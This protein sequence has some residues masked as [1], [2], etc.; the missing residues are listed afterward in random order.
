MGNMTTGNI[1]NRNMVGG[2]IDQTATPTVVDPVIVTQPAPVVVNQP[3]PTI[4]NQP[5]PIIV[6]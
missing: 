2:M 5:A 6:P 3:A 4:V 1:G